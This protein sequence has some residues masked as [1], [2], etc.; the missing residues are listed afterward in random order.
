MEKELLEMKRK[1]L[2]AEIEMNGMK[3]ENIQ[4][5]IMRDSLTYGEDSFYSLIS[6]YNLDDEIEEDSACSHGDCLKWKIG[7]PTELGD[8]IVTVMHI[9]TGTK[10]VVVDKYDERDS[11]SFK[12]GYETKIKG[13]QKFK[14]LAYMP[15][16]NCYEEKE[17]LVGDN[18]E[19]WCDFDE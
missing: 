7:T 6:K 12:W 9:S 5:S 11:G 14:V 17:F 8:Y 18:N 16:P 2:C 10:E 15:L 1:M 3:A 19:M 13:E 4:R